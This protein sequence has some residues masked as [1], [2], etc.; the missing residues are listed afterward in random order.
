MYAVKRWIAGTCA[1]LD[2]FVVQLLANPSTTYTDTAICSGTAI[3]L[4]AESATRYQWNN[5]DTTQQIQV[6]DAGIYT[7]IKSIPPCEG[8]ETFEVTTYPLPQIT[9]ADTTVCFDETTQL[10]LD[11]GHFEKYLWE[12][13]GETT[14]MVLIDKAQL[15]QLT[16]TDS[17]TCISSKEF[18][19]KE[20]CPYS[21]YVPNAFTP[22]NDG[23]NDVLVIQGNRID[24]FHLMIMDRWGK[25]V[26]ETNRID[27]YW[28][29][30]NSADGVYVIF[31]E[32]VAQGIKD[33]YTGT[34]T[35]VR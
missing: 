6:N 1:E 26:F 29:G 5:G 3:L 23:N 22:N 19:V 32:Y 21:L 27:H 20:A 9:L 17:N 4:Q 35:L 2:T 12:P 34:V 18:A 30:L 28:N 15:Y 14:R 24:T 8:T 25:I 13:I 16:V 31:I 10:E 33:N 7:V 11:A